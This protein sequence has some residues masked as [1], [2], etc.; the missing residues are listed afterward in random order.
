[1]GNMDCNLASLHNTRG[2]EENIFSEPGSPIFTFHQLQEWS[3]VD[4]VDT[5]PY[6]SNYL[7]LIHMGWP[8]CTYIQTELV[9]IMRERND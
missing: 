5:L 8:F 9:Q 7:S 6:E 4:I 2:D 1:M 3:I